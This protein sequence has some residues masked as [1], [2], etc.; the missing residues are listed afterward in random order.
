LNTLTQ[1]AVTA[2]PVGNRINFGIYH[3]MK[4]ATGLQSW[5]ARISRLRSAPLVLCRQWNRIKQRGNAGKLY[6][7]EITLITLQHFLRTALIFFDTLSSLRERNRINLIPFYKIQWLTWGLSMVVAANALVNNTKR[8]RIGFYTSSSGTK[9]T[10][11]NAQ[12][13][14][15]KLYTSTV[16]PTQSSYTTDSD[17]K[18]LKLVFFEKDVNAEFYFGYISCSRD[19]FHL[20]YIGDENWD[21]HNIPLDDKKYIVERTYFI[22]YYKKD[23]LLL[24]QNHLG[25]KDSDLAFILYQHSEI[26][27]PVSFE[28]IWKKESVKELLETGTALRSCE[29]TLAAPRKFNAVDYDLSNSFSKSMIEMMAGMGGSHLKLSLR[30]RASQRKLIRGYLSDEVKSGIKELIEKVPFLVKKANVTQPKDTKTKSLLDQ[31][32]ISE[33]NVRTKDGYA[34]FSDVRI[35]LLNAKIDNQSYLKQYE[36]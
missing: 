7:I 20:P 4:G 9:T 26:T 6:Y 33:K 25:P 5:T 16:T 31:V 35:A 29:I 34:T 17:K 12:V 36:I 10:V 3:N 18:K 32:L 19:G 11:S 22:Y 15:E 14:F 24:S 27:K 21:E 30:G 23:I 1:N 13:A 2:L 28:A 8:M